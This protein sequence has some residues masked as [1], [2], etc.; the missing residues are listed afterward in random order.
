MNNIAPHKLNLVTGKQKPPWLLQVYTPTCSLGSADQLLLSVPK[1]K[2]KLRGDR[3][4]A[5]VAPE[6][7]N[8]LPLHIKQ[9][10]SLSVFKSLLKT[11]LFF[12][13]FD[14]L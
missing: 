2:R 8:N 10:S 12:M 5:V 4:F 13:A 3:A 11:G 6:L 1:T 7:W 9:A 14:T